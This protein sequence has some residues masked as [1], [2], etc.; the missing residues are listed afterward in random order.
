MGMHV[1]DAG[2]E[3]EPAGI[4]GLGPLVLDLADGGDLAVLDREI[5][6]AWLVAQ[7]VDDGGSA[8][9]EIGQDYLRR[10]SAP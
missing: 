2:R 10:L 7:A 4:D 9:D 8:N 6:A 1:D 5:G 3:R